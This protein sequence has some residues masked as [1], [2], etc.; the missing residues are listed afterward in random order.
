MKHS[1]RPGRTAEQDVEEERT[2]THERTDFTRKTTHGQHTR[3]HTHIHTSTSTG[4]ETRADPKERHK[5]ILAQ[6]RVGGG[7]AVCDETVC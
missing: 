5:Q 1:L 4:E 7:K 6:E 2:D 3:A